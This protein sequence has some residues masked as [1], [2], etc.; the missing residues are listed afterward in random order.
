MTDC[1]KSC[2]LC[3]KHEDGPEGLTWQKPVLWIVSVLFLVWMAVTLSSISLV[4]NHGNA[5]VAE[6]QAHF[7]KQAEEQGFPEHPE[8]YDIKPLPWYVR[9]YVSMRRSHRA[10]YEP[11]PPS[12]YRENV[13]YS[14]PYGKLGKKEKR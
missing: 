7:A 9:Y 2:E 4:W 10:Y 3:G 1:D 13:K 14:P 12:C 5:V 11:M 8:Y 6:R